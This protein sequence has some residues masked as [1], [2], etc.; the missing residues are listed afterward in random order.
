MSFQIFCF[1]SHCRVRNCFSIEGMFLGEMIT[2][3]GQKSFSANYILGYHVI[4]ATLR[5]RRDPVRNSFCMSK[6]YASKRATYFSLSRSS[7]SVS[8]L[9]SPK[10]NGSP[11]KAFRKNNKNSKL[12][13][14]L[15]ILIDH[16]RYV[17]YISYNFCFL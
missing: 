10:S 7:F 16:G 17:E 6:S 11:G 2:Y 14:K 4:D 8:I 9:E 13:M 15:L 5:S 1:H 12:P 3:G